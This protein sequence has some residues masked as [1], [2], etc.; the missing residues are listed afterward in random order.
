MAVTMIEFREIGLENLDEVIELRVR[1]EQ[2]GLVADNLYSIAQAGLSAMAWCRGVYL[3][4]KAVGFFYVR[5]K[6]E[7]RRVYLC[8][9]MVD[10]R[11]QGQ[12]L[13]RRIMRQLLDDLFSSPLVEMVD[14]AV[15]REEGGA[16][17]FYKKCGFEPTGEAY[18]G[19]FKMILS[20]ERYRER[21]TGAC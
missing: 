2:D 11:W 21:C 14:L 8:R 16:E 18:R 1:K 5:E 15:S 13:G 3:D 12:G 7:G 4:G 20:R 9:F 6:D 10:Q 19:G 17:E